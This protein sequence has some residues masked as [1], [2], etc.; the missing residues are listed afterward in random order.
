MFEGFDNV[1]GDRNRVPRDHSS[2]EASHII[3][4]GGV[5]SWFSSALVGWN[6]SAT[7]FSTATNL[8]GPWSQ[9]EA[10][11]H[12]TALAGDS[13]NTQHHFVLTVAG[14]EVT[15]HV[16]VGDRY[17]QWTQRGTGRQHLPAFGLASAGEP[18]LRCAREYAAHRHPHGAIHCCER[19]RG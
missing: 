5:Y 1:S 7:M 18:V 15:T 12:R 11:A 13:F 9:L 10:S 8:A 2:R 3:N 6:S 17:S 14:S 19:R 16:Y 4:V